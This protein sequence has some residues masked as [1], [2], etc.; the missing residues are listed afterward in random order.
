M[1]ASYK[2]KVTQLLDNQCFKQI[3]VGCLFFL[4]IVNSNDL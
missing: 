2:K 3:L 1:A 4:N